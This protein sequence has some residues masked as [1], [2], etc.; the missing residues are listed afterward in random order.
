M[1]KPLSQDLRVRVV[2]AFE[3]G[4]SRRAAAEQ[5]GIAP[6]AAVKWLRLWRDTG[7]VEPRPQG[8]DERSGRIEALADAILG[9]V[10]E[11]PDII[12]VKI[13]DRLEAEHGQCFAPSTVHRFFARRGITFKKRSRTPPSRVRVRPVPPSPLLAHHHGVARPI[14]GRSQCRRE[15]KSKDHQSGADRALISQ[16]SRMLRRSPWRKRIARTNVVLQIRNDHFDS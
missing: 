8:G 7:A 2:G 15:R 14:C 1:T 5:F 11:A 16:S 4:M 9:Y 6:S 13:A 3:G 12:L 10:A